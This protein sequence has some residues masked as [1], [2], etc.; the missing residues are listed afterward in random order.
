MICS[1][2]DLS[3]LIG[4]TSRLKMLDEM[5]VQVAAADLE[6]SEQGYHYYTLMRGEEE[7]REEEIERD[8]GPEPDDS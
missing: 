8:F 2:A 6:G 5:A 1:V 7:E 4:Y 3:L